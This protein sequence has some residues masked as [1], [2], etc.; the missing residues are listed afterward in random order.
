V[1]GSDEI[2]TFLEEAGKT[3]VCFP[4][5]LS[6]TMRVMGNGYCV[7]VAVLPAVTSPHGESHGL[8]I[9]TNRLSCFVGGCLPELLPELV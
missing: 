2:G 7:D 6:T 3:H 9:L 8:P 1:F 4:N 5:A